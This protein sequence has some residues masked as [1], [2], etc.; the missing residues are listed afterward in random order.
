MIGRTALAVLAFACALPF[1]AGAQT[2]RL[3]VGDRGTST[4]YSQQEL[5]DR[6][7]A[8][9]ITLADPVYGRT[10]SYHAVPVANLMKNLKVAPDDYVQARA[11]DDFSIG[12]PARLAIN[13]NPAQPQAFIAIE[14]PASPWPALPSHPK[15]SAG[16]FYLIWQLGPGARVPSE[17]WSYRLAALTVTDSPLQRWPAL[18]VG[19]EVPA[20]DPIRVGLERYLELCIACHRFKGAGEG[21]QGPDLGQPMNPVQ[22]FQPPALKKLIRDPTTVRRWP[23]MRMPGF[24]SARLSDSDLDA[25]VAWLAYKAQRP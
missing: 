22:Y 12:V 23:D 10:M 2:A 11:T 21:E 16:P 13:T 9:Q 6:G 25:I 17:Y 1:G 24:D 3:T 20:N 8:R 5:L 15:D 19:P 7:D 14:A 4:S 18:R